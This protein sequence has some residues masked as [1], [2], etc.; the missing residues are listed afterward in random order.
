VAAFNPLF[1]IFSLY[2]VG[3]FPDQWDTFAVIVSALMCVG[4]LVLGIFT[5]GRLE[6]SVLK[7][8]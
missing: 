3:F 8:L 7:E 6:R 1:G 5:F 4:F 2:R